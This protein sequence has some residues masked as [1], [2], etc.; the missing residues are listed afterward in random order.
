MYDGHRMQYARLAR[1]SA[2]QGYVVYS[3]VLAATDGTSCNI[4]GDALAA[5]AASSTAAFTE[6]T[7]LAASTT[8]K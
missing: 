5:A 2:L 6:V 3:R 4:D 7:R 1:S 8:V